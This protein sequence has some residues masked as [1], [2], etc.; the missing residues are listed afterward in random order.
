MA[1]VQKPSKREIALAAALALLPT[2]LVAEQAHAYIGPGAGFAFVGSLL[3]LLA[4]F[5]MA[6][7]IILTWPMRLLYRQI[8]VGN[9]YKNA[10]SRRVVMFSSASSFHMR[11]STHSVI[12]P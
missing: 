11:P 10:Q 3:V 12:S 6:F 1:R 5:A 2:L 7:A 9:P 8:T 4:T